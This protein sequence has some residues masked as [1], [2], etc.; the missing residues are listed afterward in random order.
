MQRPS[1]GWRP[2]GW[3]VKEQAASYHGIEGFRQ[4]QGR[5]AA[6]RRFARYRTLTLFSY[7]A[8]RFMLSPLLSTAEQSMEFEVSFPA[9]HPE[10]AIPGHLPS[11]LPPLSMAVSRLAAARTGAGTRA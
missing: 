6:G 7:P 10:I 4:G 8:K 1:L 11:F 5:G 9:G 3:L 2:M